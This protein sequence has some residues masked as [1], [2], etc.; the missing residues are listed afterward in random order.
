[1]ILSHRHRF[2]FLKMRKTAG[3]SIEIA[4]SK[5]CGPEDIITPLEPQDQAI[6]DRLGYP[7]PQNHLKKPGEYGAGDIWRLVRGRRRQV[8]YWDH[9]G[10][11]QLRR[12]V[13]PEIWNSYY[14]FCFERN[15]WDKVVSYYHYIR[16][17]HAR[18]GG[19]SVPDSIEEFVECGWA[20]QVS[21]FDRYTIDDSLAVDHVGRYENL[22]TELGEIARRL[23]LPESLTLPSAKVGIRKQSGSLSN[24][25]APAVRE[26]I[27]EMFSREIRMFGFRFEDA[28]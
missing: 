14:K 25:L 26:K 20:G 12:H 8:R 17:F 15:P 7:G 10:A 11:K 23:N 1:M 19:K 4:L 24:T 27:R 5:F 2:I 3:T 22:N 18:G 21:D 16:D 13:S 9:I 6:R 28:R